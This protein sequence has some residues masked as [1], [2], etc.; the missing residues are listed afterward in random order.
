MLGRCE[1][2]SDIQSSGKLV[3]T[4]KGVA[5]LLPEWEELK[6]HVTRVDQCIRDNGENEWMLG[7][8]NI[9]ITVNDFAGEKRVHVRQYFTPD[10]IHAPHTLVPTKRGAALKL[11]EWDALKQHMTAVDNAIKELQQPCYYN[12]ADYY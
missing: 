6:Q 9:R 1:S 8:R 4:K 7:S 3:P 12:P 10:P 11:A 2:T 5:L